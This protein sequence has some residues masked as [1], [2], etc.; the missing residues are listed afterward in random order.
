MR[1]SWVTFDPV[2]I[3]FNNTIKY[4]SEWPNHVLIHKTWSLVHTGS[5]VALPINA[6]TPWHLLM[7][8]EVMIVSFSAVIV[9]EFFSFWG[10]H[11]THMWLRVKWCS[12]PT[13][14]L[15]GYVITLNDGNMHA[16]LIDGRMGGWMYWLCSDISLQWTLISFT[17]SF[18]AT[19]PVLMHKLFLIT[20]REQRTLV[21]CTNLKAVHGLD[22]VCVYVQT[23]AC[24]VAH[25]CKIAA[26]VWREALY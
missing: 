11:D 24:Q 12:R 10:V 20:K 14:T 6:S 16:W 18:T 23:G 25:C 19:H 17:I 21:R 7:Y 1:F 3:L 8:I 5:Y 15:G 22:V 9:C 13:Q 4:F 2:P 26:E